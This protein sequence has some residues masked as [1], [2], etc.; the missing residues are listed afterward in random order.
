MAEKG[1]YCPME[2]CSS[3]VAGM[4]NISNGLLLPFSVI[5]ESQFDN[6]GGFT[7]AP[8]MNNMMAEG[9]PPHMP[10]WNN[11]RSCPYL[12]GQLKKK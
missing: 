11:W 10:N 9:A 1:I 5:G 3:N 4:C 2:K 8:L 7:K 12:R 6:T